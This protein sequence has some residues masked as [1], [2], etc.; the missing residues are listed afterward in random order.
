MKM[1]KMKT[2]K[3]KIGNTKFVTKPSKFG[4][5]KSKISLKKKK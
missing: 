3:G 1:K 4:M 5:E 2:K